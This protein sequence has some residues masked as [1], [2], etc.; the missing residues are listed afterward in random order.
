[1]S[2]PYCGCSSFGLRSTGGA[3]EQHQR[4]YQHLVLCRHSV[5]KLQDH[6][7]PLTGQEMQPGQLP[8]TAAH[9]RPRQKVFES[10]SISHGFDG[11]VILGCQVIHLRSSDI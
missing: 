7:R 4:V 5:H 11:A 2:V 6:Y 10:V 1:M 9:G 8:L 3:H